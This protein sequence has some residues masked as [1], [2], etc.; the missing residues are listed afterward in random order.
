M[1]VFISWSGDRS[2]AAAKMLR[3]FLPTI[4]QMVRTVISTDD[5]QSGT[6]WFSEIRRS[7]EESSIGVLCITRDNFLN[8]WIAFEAGALSKTSAAV[9]P[10]L[11]DV[12]PVDLTG[13]LAAFQLVVADREGTLQLL[14]VINRRLENPLP[15]EM[16]I[17]SFEIFWPDFE[18]HLHNL[19]PSKSSSERTPTPD[20]VDREKSERD[21][22]KEILARLEKIEKDGA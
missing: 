3:D 1:Q 2:L 7:I 21:L 18:R 8:P 4:I 22:L 6:R 14:N 19:P 13:P 12:S 9:I 11:I 15:Q 10:Y 17:R 20:M 16:L 5:L